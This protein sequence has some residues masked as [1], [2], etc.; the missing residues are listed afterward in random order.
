VIPLLLFV[1]ITVGC[2]L[3]LLILMRVLAGETS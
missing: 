3:A 2:L 1:G